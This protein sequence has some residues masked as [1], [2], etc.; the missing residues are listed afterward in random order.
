MDIPACFNRER[1]APF[2]S[3]KRTCAGKAL[4]AAA[5]L[6]PGRFDRVVW[7]KLPDVDGRTAILRRYFKPLRLDSSI[8]VESIATELSSMT[9]GASGADLEYLCQ[10][11]A[12]VCVKEAIRLGL[13]PESMTICRSH[14]EAALS[15]LR[16]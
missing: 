15:A 16:E 14:L 5:L 11:A 4:F 7:M 8:D 1:T 9:D 12:R 3:A 6:R 2:V 10:T 13:S